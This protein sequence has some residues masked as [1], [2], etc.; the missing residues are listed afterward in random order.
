MAW[1]FS[2]F[3]SNLIHNILNILMTLNAIILWAGCSV[4]AS[5]QATCTQTWIPPEIAIII[6]GVAAPLK[7]VMNVMRDGIPG[8]FKPQPPVVDAITKV[9]VKTVAVKK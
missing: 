7:I 2:L 8:L 5:G 9:E 3:N 1:I 4:N 6:I